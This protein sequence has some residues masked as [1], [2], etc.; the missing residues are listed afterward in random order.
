MHSEP[1]LV[2]QWTQEMSLSVFYVE[3]CRAQSSNRF[4]RHGLNIIEESSES[5]KI[6]TNGIE[7]PAT[8]HSALQ[9]SV[10]RS[11][12]SEG[13]GRKREADLL[14]WPFMGKI[15]EDLELWAL[16]KW[17]CRSSKLWSCHGSCA[18]PFDTGEESD[19]AESKEILS[20]KG[21]EPKKSCNE[22][23]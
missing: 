16:W 9:G 20:L 6:S 4:Q 1:L 3:G 15:F 22:S 8:R 10:S 11:Q 23:R 12:I 14:P 2:A 18:M 19:R 13:E 7:E 21:D 17:L 5:G